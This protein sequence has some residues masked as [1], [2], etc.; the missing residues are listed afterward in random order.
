ML[1]RVCK[2]RHWQPCFW[3]WSDSGH[4]PP[5]SAWGVRYDTS[6]PWRERDV[7]PLQKK[8]KTD[9]ADQTG[10]LKRSQLWWSTWRPWHWTLETTP[11][12]YK[13]VTDTKSLFPDLRGTVFYFFYF[14]FFYNFFFFNLWLQWTKSCT[15]RQKWM[16][17]CEII[18]LLARHTAIRQRFL[19]S[20]SHAPTCAVGSLAVTLIQPRT[21]LPVMHWCDYG[22]IRQTPQSQ[23][24]LTCARV[25]RSWTTW[26]LHLWQ[27]LPTADLRR[28]APGRYVLSPPPGVT[29]SVSLSPLCFAQCGVPQL[30]K[31]WL[32]SMMAEQLDHCVF[33]PQNVHLGSQIIYISNYIV[34]E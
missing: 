16:I 22:S 21:E 5:S 23:P 24:F 18:N 33:R 28:P 26:E 15:F 1:S 6:T 12:P 31:W 11:I 3:K 10:T 20:S 30:T 34:A 25:V 2:H 8:T 14:Y 13:S 32:V 17:C 7:T 9:R 19:S 29:H 27:S 4:R